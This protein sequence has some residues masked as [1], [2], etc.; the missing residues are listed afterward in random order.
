MKDAIDTT[1]TKDNDT[2]FFSGVWPRV[3][4]TQPKIIELTLYTPEAKRKHAI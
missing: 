1:F 3:A 2:A 4:E